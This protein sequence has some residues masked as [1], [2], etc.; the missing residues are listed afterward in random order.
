VVKESSVRIRCPRRGFTLIELLVVIAIIAVLIGLLL[1]AVQA[2]REAARRAQCVNNLKQ[3][4]LALHNYHDALGAF[5]MSYAARAKFV[6]GATDTAPG[7]GWTTMVLP[8]ME[9]SPIFNSVNFV[10]AVEA[11]QNTTVIRS[12]LTAY[13]CPSDIT[14]GPFQVLDGSTPGNALTT[15]T[16]S[17]YAACVGNDLTDA[18][19]GL[20]ND[21]LGN[22][23]M[24][25]NSG[26]RLAGITDGS[27][28]TIMVGERAWANV[29]GV[30]AG[31]ITNG[32][33]RRGAMNRCPLTGALFYPAAP[34]VQA[35]GH[36][37][38]TDTDEDGGLDDFS[39][40]HPGGANFVFADGSV[41]FLKTVLRD[42]GKTPNGATIYSP[43][44][45][46]FQALTTR[47]G[48]EVVSSD[49][50]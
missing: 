48:C 17:S 9:Q 23:V 50:Y 14:S 1:P 41:R 34:L 25:R 4:G 16:P 8:Q 19:T 39:S 3:M 33:T 35:H 31:V 42:S 32:T 24:F 12:Q 46:V 21:G 49:S 36:L 28:L 20:N 11:P 44:S 6:D 15:M 40:L 7:W 22:G 2:A 37:M 30:W 47:N 18:T 38:N 45:L 13:V 26:I 29:K 10:L 5:P 43:S 27:S